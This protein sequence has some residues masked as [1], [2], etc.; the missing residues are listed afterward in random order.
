[1]AKEEFVRVRKGVHRLV[2]CGPVGIGID[3]VTH[4]R[5]L[6]VK[7]DPIGEIP[8]LIDDEDYRRLGMEILAEIGTSYDFGEPEPEPEIPNSQVVSGP[9]PDDDRPPEGGNA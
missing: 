4:R 9:E 1:M 5:V 2:S 3:R 7:F 8:I 6:I